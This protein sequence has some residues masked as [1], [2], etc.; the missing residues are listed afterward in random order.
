MKRITNFAVI[1]LAAIA[2]TS[3]TITRP[4]AVTEEEVGTKTGSSSTTVLF[5]TWYLNKNY[6]VAEAV[7][8]SKMK[9]GVATVDIKIKNYIFFSKK[10]LIVTGK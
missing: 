6:G 1:A 10:E 8:N 9:G 7:K 5:G 4:Y 3:C 2:I